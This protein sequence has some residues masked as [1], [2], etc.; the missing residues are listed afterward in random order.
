VGGRE[1][2][3]LIDRERGY[4]DERRNIEIK[5]MTQRYEDGEIETEIGERR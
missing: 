2:V 1:I 3:R 4:E 5:E